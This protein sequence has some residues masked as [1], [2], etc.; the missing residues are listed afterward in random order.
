[1]SA[2]S[3]NTNGRINV[4]EDRLRAVLA[5]FK[6]DLISN[7]SDRFERK[8]DV[9]QLTDARKELISLEKR[10]SSLEKWRYALATLTTVAL[11]LAGIV[12]QYHH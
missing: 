7:L 11:A 5:E 3:E 8:A 12:A 9:M 6:L 4:S 1:M 10:V 2:D